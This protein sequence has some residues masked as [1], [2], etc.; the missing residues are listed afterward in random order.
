MAGGFGSLLVS[1]NQWLRGQGVDIFSNLP[2]CPGN[3]SNFLGGTY[4]GEKW[5]CVELPQ[6]LYTTRH[7]HTGFFPGV[8]GAHQIWDV[9]QAMGM[10]R[11]PNGSNYVPV[12][13]D[14]IVVKGMPGAEFGHVSVV[15]RAFPHQGYIDAREQ[16]FGF[17]QQTGIGR[18]QWSG[19]WVRR[20]GVWTADKI[21]G[22]VHAPANH[23]QPG[24]GMLGTVFDEP[25][26]DEPAENFNLLS[27]WSFEDGDTGWSRIALPDAVTYEVRDDPARSQDGDRFLEMRTSRDGGSVGQ[28]IAVVPA[29]QQRYFFSIW[30][31][32][33]E[34]APVPFDLEAVLTAQGGQE[35]SASSRAGIG[36]EWALVT[37]LLNIGHGNHTGL[38]AE[39]RMHT[40]GTPID[41]DAASL[42]EDE[43]DAPDRPGP[44]RPENVG[45]PK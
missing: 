29:P 18:Y 45:A 24:H 9:A 36:H 43:Q 35:E 3:C 26:L 44:S 30:A 32:V 25:P 23:M 39:I 31:R 34:D 38:R 22:F 17:N 33:P 27:N 11:H 8:Q 28:D 13:G 6:R 2:N 16:N 7:W 5:Q 12:P 40:T 41:V 21:F 4:V 10:V 42:F 19:H 14:M 20:D 37:V 1:G 15:N